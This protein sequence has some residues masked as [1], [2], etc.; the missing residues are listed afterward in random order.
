MQWAGKSG[1]I[2]RGLSFW[3]IA[4]LLAAHSFAADFGVPAQ[5]AAA[6]EEPSP[7]QGAQI[8]KAPS[9]VKP[10]QS[11]SA[12]PNQGPPANKP[13]TSTT[14]PRETP[15]AA[16]PEE[17]PKAEEEKP[18]ADKLTGGWCGQ[19]AKL[20]EK[21]IDIEV[22]LEGA[23]TWNLIGG[24][25]QNG[26]PACEY[27]FDARMTVK[28]EPLFHYPGGIFFIDF[29]SH[30]GQS[31]SVR[32]VGSFVPIVTI[33]APAFV[34]LYALWYKQVFGKDLF[35]ILVGKSD[36]YDNFTHT[37]HSLQF[38]NNNYSTLPTILF[39]PTYPNP[40]MSVVGS[41]NFPKG[42]SFTL[43]LFD[44]SLANRV[45]TGKRGVFGE[46]FHD[47]PHHAF[48]IGEL[49]FSWTGKYTGRLAFGGWGST[50]RFRKFGDATQR[51]TSGPYMTIDQIVYKTEKEEVAFVFIGG[52]ANPVVS[53][54]R[55]AFAT[56]LVWK[57]AFA[58]RPQD[59]LGIGVSGN[60]FTDEPAAGFTRRYE[61]YYEVYYQWQVTPWA[62]LEP[63]FQYVVN[64]GGKG[65][66]NA[67]VFSLYFNIDF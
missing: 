16:K 9:G 29:E 55:S 66:P 3:L 63:D 51:G 28:S 38:L 56:G 22:S 65:L 25:H 27:L 37:A 41:I 4:L 13:I 19:R 43:G 32:Y 20:L 18:F 8:K 49:G 2:G 6:T 5:E 14:Q 61:T 42:I 31:P 21:G 52:L 64:P 59:T 34:E 58:P 50:A 26:W 17:S 45:K 10:Q 62:F 54:I 12:L 60:F 15:S 23:A 33:E 39:F 30:H 11:P 47:L 40:A 44:G 35:W 24:K 46:F 48:L 57:G 53:A 7:K 36:A 67:F 1:G